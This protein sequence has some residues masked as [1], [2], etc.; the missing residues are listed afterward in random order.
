MRL[1]IFYF[2]VYLISYA[3][4]HYIKRYYRYCITLSNPGID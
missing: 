1:L 2:I 3:H 4:V